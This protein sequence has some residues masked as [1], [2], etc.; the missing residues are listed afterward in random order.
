MEFVKVCCIILSFVATS[1]CF[2]DNGGET[3]VFDTDKRLQMLETEN[4]Q[5]RTLLYSL[6][7]QMSMVLSKLQTLQSEYDTL[8]KKDKN[9]AFF[10]YLKNDLV[11]PTSGTTVVFDEIVTNAGRDYDPTHGVYSAPINGSYHF[12]V[13]AA[14]PNTPDQHGTHL[15]LMKNGM[16]VAYLFLDS[17]RAN[18]LWTSNS[19]SAVLHLNTNDRV[20]VQVDGTSGN[21]TLAGHRLSDGAQHT[22]ISG[23]F[24]H[25]D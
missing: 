9:S 13:T 20:W 23:F 16:K 24:I 5:Q 11:N 8:S 10:A 4:S 22:H 2:L 1:L 15:F 12:S 17:Q 3:G 19:V 18:P 21:H 14:S 6:S 25:A 7:N